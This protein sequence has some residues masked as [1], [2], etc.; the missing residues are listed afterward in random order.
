MRAIIAIDILGGKCVR[1]SQ[2]NFSKCKIYS[3]NPVEVAKKIEASGMRY[4]HLVDLDGAKEGKI[5]NIAVLGKI[6][7]QTSL[8]IDFGGGIRSDEDIRAAFGAGAAQVNCGS[9]AVKQ[10]DKFLKWLDIY[11]PGKIIL[12]A[13]AAGRKVVTH[14]WTED[15]RTDVTGF[16]KE[17]SS[18]GV[19]YIVCTDIAK[20]GMM[21]GP[22]TD[23]YREI[24][25]ECRIN[26]I[27]SGGISST[28]DL[29]E[30]KKAG[31]EGAI[32][33]KAFYEGLIKPEELNAIC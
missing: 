27:A 19:Q 8:K 24:L 16:I 1:L 32:I 25:S 12:S 29:L 33:G 3:S 20:D 4:L 14:G 26:L 22:S 17:F 11:G 13:D 18:L 2:G 28:E 21:Q 9:I 6:A 10:R 31:C 30:L 15:S 5:I 7:S 23:L